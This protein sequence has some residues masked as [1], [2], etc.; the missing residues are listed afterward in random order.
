MGEAAAEEELTCAGT[1]AW[2]IG[3]ESRCRTCMQRY[4]A[5][6]H[7]VDRLDDELPD[8]PSGAAMFCAEQIGFD[9]SQSRGDTTLI[10]IQTFHGDRHPRLPTHIRG[11]HT[12]P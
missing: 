10:L 3:V 12:W 6:H 5:P 9:L 8:R 2:C 11:S 4:I 7:G 1:E